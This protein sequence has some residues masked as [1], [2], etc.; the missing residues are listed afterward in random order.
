MRF[1]DHVDLCVCVCIYSSA[2]V[3]SQRLISRGSKEDDLGFLIIESFGLE[4]PSKVVGS[5]L[6]WKWE[7]LLHL[8]SVPELCLSSSC[9]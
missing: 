9:A 3:T 4:N 2:L 6:G 7:Q 5:E 8:Q 1:I